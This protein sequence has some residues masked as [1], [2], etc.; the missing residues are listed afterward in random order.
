MHRAHSVNRMMQCRP[1]V[2]LSPETNLGITIEKEFF[3]FLSFDFVVF[4]G[5]SVNGHNICVCVCVCVRERE[6][7]SVC[8]CV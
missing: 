7:E 3:F 6:R 1:K 8:V 4:K 2:D 5:G